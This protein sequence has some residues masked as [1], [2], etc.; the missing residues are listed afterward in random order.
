MA[1]HDLSKPFE[2]SK[3]EWALGSNLIKLWLKQLFAEENHFAHLSYLGVPIPTDAELLMYLFT[4]IVGV[5][6]ARAGAR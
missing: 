6:V 2:G 3:D 1:S 4:C 5:S